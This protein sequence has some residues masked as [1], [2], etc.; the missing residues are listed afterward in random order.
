MTKV[1]NCLRCG[2]IWKQRVKAKPKNCPRC[3]S[4]YWDTSKKRIKKEELFGYMHDVALIQEILVR[5][6]NETEG[7]RDEAG[8]L[9]SS[10]KILEMRNQK[11]NPFEVAA[12]IYE[13][14]TRKHFFHEANK[15]I[16]KI[17]ADAE[18]IEAGYMTSFDAKRDGD[19]VRKIS[20]YKS[21]VTRDEIKGWIISRAKQSPLKYRKKFKQAYILS[22][23]IRWTFPT[24]YWRSWETVSST[25]CALF[26]RASSVRSRRPLKPSARTR[27]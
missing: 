22:H 18:L 13:E 5:Q 24:R 4:P 10:A 7:I 25:H 23:K 6:T 15:R 12:V 26:R 14:F 1:N 20:K 17:L 19:F 3:H 9:F 2:H 16:A 11:E 8:I 21:P 27:T